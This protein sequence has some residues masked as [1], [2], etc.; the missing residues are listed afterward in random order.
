MSTHMKE[1]RTC[2]ISWS[3]EFW[4]I[5]YFNEY[6][7]TWI[8]LVRVDPAPLE[9][10]ITRVKKLDRRQALSRHSSYRLRNTVSGEIIPW[11]FL[12]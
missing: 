1:T 2:T 3:P 10:L 4:L 12:S 9:I 6:E 8:Q 7:N 11:D 5:E